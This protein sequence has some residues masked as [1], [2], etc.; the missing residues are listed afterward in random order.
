VLVEPGADALADGLRRAA[1][2]TWDA[3]RIRQHAERFSRDRFAR[4]I[5]RAIE[6]T[7]AMPAGQ[8]W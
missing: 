4:E 5:Q 6:E 3:A 7:M 2:M 1:N 8:P